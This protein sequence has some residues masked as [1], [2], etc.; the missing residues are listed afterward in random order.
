MN[1]RIY[2]KEL[3]Q[4]EVNRIRIGKLSCPNCFSSYIITYSGDNCKCK[5]C[6]SKFDFK[7]LL[8][9]TQVRDKKIEQIL[10]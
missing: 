2:P 6:Q 3:Y 4:K 8:N 7:N 5:K 1:S 9:Q 10:S